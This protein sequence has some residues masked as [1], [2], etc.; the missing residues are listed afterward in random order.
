MVVLLVPLD[1]LEQQVRE[2]QVLR[3]FKVQQVVKDL[4]VL[5]A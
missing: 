1:L 4:L 3:A 5:L 2:P